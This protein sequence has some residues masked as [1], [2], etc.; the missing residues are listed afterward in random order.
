MAM[1]LCGASRLSELDR[2][3]LRREGN[4]PAARKDVV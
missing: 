1:A 2:G 4:E 3:L